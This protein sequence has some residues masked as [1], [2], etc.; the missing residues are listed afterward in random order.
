MRRILGT[1]IV[2]SLALLT[3]AGCI[4]YDQELYIAENGSGGAKVH[5]S[6]MT[7]DTGVG[8]ETD[9]GVVPESFVTDE[10]EIREMYEGKGVDLKGVKV[11]T[12][13]AV[14]DVYLVIE[15]K[16]V[17]DL[18]GHGVWDENQVIGTRIEDGKLVFIQDI[19][20][21]DARTLTSDEKR[22][23]D[24]YR[25][26]YALTMPNEIIKTN[27][28]VGKDGRTVY[29]AY[30]LSIVESNPHLQMHASCEAPAGYKSNR[31]GGSPGIFGGVSAFFVMGCCAIL[32][33]IIVIITI[34]I[35][36]KKKKRRPSIPQAT[37]PQPDEITPSPATKPEEPTAEDNIQNATDDDS[38]EP[39]PEAPESDAQDKSESEE[40][41]LEPDVEGE[42]ESKPEPTPEPP[43]RTEER[44]IKSE[45][46]NKQNDLKDESFD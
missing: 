1:T 26:T 16:N 3:L 4:T 5:Y 7:M 35:I 40:K 34:V 36:V 22:L 8:T 32:F 21:P 10:V 25:F 15:F 42:P 27:G 20:N 18:N 29:W 30:P 9:T 31:S 17:L 19:S 6:V 2:I 23:Y 39:E 45:P 11:K 38:P 33:I 46:D 24:E 14:T 43:E 13:E 12:S 28:V 44:D 37:R 41:T